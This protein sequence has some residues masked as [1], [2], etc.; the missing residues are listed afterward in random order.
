[1]MS[2]QKIAAPRILNPNGWHVKLHNWIGWSYSKNHFCP[3]FWQTVLALLIVVPLAVA[4]GTSATV[5]AGGRGIANATGYI[6]YILGQGGLFLWGHLPVKSVKRGLAKAW[7]KI[8]TYLEERSDAHYEKELEYMLYDDGAAA[9]LAHA[10]SRGGFGVGPERFQRSMKNHHTKDYSLN[11]RLKEVVKRNGLLLPRYSGDTYDTN[12]AFLAQYELGERWANETFIKQQKRE[13]IRG[14]IIIS[15]L[16][17]TVLMGGLFAY[18][19]SFI[20]ALKYFGMVVGGATALAA[21][22]FFFVS[23]VPLMYYYFKDVVMEK[24]CP[25]IVWSK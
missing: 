16:V 6:G 20:L 23:I 21:V 13:A 4:R 17:T 12:P 5:R 24:Y 7:E 14:A 15:T 18:T 3:F 8:S 9:Y 1:M 19:D 10:V 22:V 25:N 2:V 11:P